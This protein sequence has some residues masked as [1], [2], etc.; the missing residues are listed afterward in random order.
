MSD[1][2]KTKLQARREYVGLSRADV[3][4][5]AGVSAETLKKWEKGERNPRILYLKKV[6]AV[7][8]CKVDDII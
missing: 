6:A 8:N 4:R 5:L 1:R 3:A 7:L 2:P